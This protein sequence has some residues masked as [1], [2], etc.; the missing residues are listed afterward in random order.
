MN[1]ICCIII[2]I[3]ILIEEQWQYRTS[4]S[5]HIKQR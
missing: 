1:I 2:K 5:S 4:Q 3:S